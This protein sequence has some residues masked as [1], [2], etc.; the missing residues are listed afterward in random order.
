VE[1]SWEFCKNPSIDYCKAWESV[2]SSILRN[3]AGDL[4]HGI[5]SPS[6]Q[7]TLYLAEK[8]ALENIKEL[9]SIE[10]TMPNKHYVNVDFSRFKGLVA[11]DEETVFLPLDKPSGVIYLKMNRVESKL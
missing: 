5:A 3:F 1:C 10:M 2:K 6:V 9:N 4:D 7:H 11:N 8:E